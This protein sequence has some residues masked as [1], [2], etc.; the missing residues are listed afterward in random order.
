MSATNHQAPYVLD[1]PMHHGTALRI[2]TH[3][4]DTVGALDALAG[5][6]RG[7]PISPIAFGGYADAPDAHNALGQRRGAAVTPGDL[8]PIIGAESQGQRLRSD[9]AMRFLTTQS[10]PCSPGSC[11]CQASYRP[12]SVTISY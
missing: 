8:L 2:G 5:S 7:R 10:G 6:A 12:D 11:E 4:T 9:E 1:G 3:Y